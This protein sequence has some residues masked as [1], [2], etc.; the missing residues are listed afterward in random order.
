MSKKTYL[1]KCNIVYKKLEENS[2][3]S[4]EEL[5]SYLLESKLAR[6]VSNLEDG[7][8]PKGFDFFYL[9]DIQKKF[10]KDANKLLNK[11]KDETNE[12]LDEQEEEYRN[13]IE[14]IEKEEF[15][16]IKSRRLEYFTKNSDKVKLPLP[17]NS[18]EE[19]IFNSENKF[20]E[21][22]QNFK[23]VASQIKKIQLNYYT[24]IKNDYEK[25]MNEALA[26][27]ILPHL[28][29]IF[30]SEC[31]YAVF[32][33]K[34]E[35]KNINEEK[36][37]MTVTPY[38]LS[39]YETISDYLKEYNGEVYRDETSTDKYGTLKD[40]ASDLMFDYTEQ[41][42]FDLFF[43]IIKD[44]FSI[45]IKE[46]LRD[47]LFAEI[48]N[49]LLPYNSIAELS[50]KYLEQVENMSIND[51]FFYYDL[52]DQRENYEY[53]LIDEK[54]FNEEKKQVDLFINSLKTKT[55]KE[56]TVFDGTQFYK[57]YVDSSNNILNNEGKN[58]EDAI[59]ELLWEIGT[60]VE[61]PATLFV[62]ESTPIKSADGTVQW[63]VSSLLIVDGQFYPIK[64]DSIKN[65]YKVQEES[66]AIDSTKG[67]IF[68]DWYF[69]HVPSFY[70]DIDIE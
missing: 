10:F 66:G 35:S 2:K 45:S 31:K 68:Y 43:N 12:I 34:D 24:R 16:K 11:I 41:F 25:F 39:N 57:F 60:D 49:C 13:Y 1:E 26:S 38:L 50:H 29:N 62:H 17:V 4:N 61:E 33:L 23:E 36:M 20:C 18:I 5:V 47:D 59:R 7:S 53:C 63:K 15:L 9:N 67:L 64:K 69:K 27:I 48:S 44:D 32:S 70:F 56:V 8:L 3:I 28:S 19:A 46:D 37:L 14:V 52:K 6:I 51:M 55:P 40:I 22:T 21:F 42:L 30:T 65:S 58:V 54:G